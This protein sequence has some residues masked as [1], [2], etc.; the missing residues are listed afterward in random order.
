MDIVGDRRFVEIPGDKL[1]ELPPLLVHAAPEQRIKRRPEKLDRVMGLAQNIVESEEL[2]NDM[3]LDPQNLALE[4]DRRK[5]DL[6]VTLVGQYMAFLNHWNWGDSVLDWIRQC[7][8]TF[9][10]RPDLR[11]LLRTDVWPHAGRASFVTL[12]E[13]KSVPTEG[14]N[15]ERAVGMRLTF[16]QPPPISCF[17]DQFLFYLN[18]TVANTAYQTWSKMGAD[19]VSSLPPERFQV[20]VV[21]M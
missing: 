9:D 2:I 19:P 16:R 6:A 15:L 17:S 10:G 13:D 18:E 14:V 11:R 20:Q 7:E 21:T 3:A 8:M 1:H 4:H 5:M 12:L